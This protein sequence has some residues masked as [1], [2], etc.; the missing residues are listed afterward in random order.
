MTKTSKNPQPHAVERKNK[1]QG[2]EKKSALAGSEL[3]KPKNKPHLSRD[4]MKKNPFFTDDYPKL[5]KNVDNYDEEND[6]F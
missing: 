2:T 6:G 3:E 5:E 4:P 1:S